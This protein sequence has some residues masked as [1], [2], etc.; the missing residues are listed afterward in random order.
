M[1]HFKPTDSTASCYTCKVMHT[2]TNRD[3]YVEHHTATRWANDINLTQSSK[4]PILEMTTQSNETTTTSKTNHNQ[5][6]TNHNQI[7]SKQHL[8]TASNSIPRR[9]HSLNITTTPIPQPSQQ[10]VQIYCQHVNNKRSSF[11]RFNFTPLHEGQTAYITQQHPIPHSLKLR[12]N[13]MTPNPDQ[14]E[15]TYPLRRPVSHVAH[16]H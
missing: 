10:M 16:V 11:A 6:K 7:N 4:P 9:T 15:T 8:Q 14:Y 12:F 2:K 3:C 1:G 13:P 5:I